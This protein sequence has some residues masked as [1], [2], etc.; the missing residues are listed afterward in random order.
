MSNHVRAAAG[1]ASIAGLHCA[2]VYWGAPPARSEGNHLLTRIFGAEIR[3]TGDFDRASVDRGIVEAAIEL[4]CLIPGFDGAFLSREWK[5]A[6]WDKFCT[7]APP[8][9]R[10]SVERYKIVKR[11]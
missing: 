11:V 5:D 6:L 3:F 1:V 7:A 9:Q 2:A 4:S 8:R 10:R